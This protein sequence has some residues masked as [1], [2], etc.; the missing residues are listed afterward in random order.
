MREADPSQ[1]CL[2][3]SARAASVGMIGLIVIC[4]AV[5]FNPLLAN[6]GIVIEQRVTTGPAGGTGRATSRTL[7]VQDD[8][9]KFVLNDRQSILID[10]NAGTVTAIDQGQKTFRELPFRK[11]MGTT[12][13]P[14]HF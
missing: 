1:F 5:I 14:N 12:L 8:K 11:V 13:D 2:M 10:A 7:M 6:A 9:E 3:C 4:L